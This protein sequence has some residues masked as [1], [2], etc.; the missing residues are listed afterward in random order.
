NDHFV[1]P[2]IY[3]NWP[4]RFDRFSF[5]AVLSRNTPLRESKDAKS[6]VI[7][8]LSFDIVKPLGEIGHVRLADGR[9]GWA[10]PRLLWSPAGYHIE[11]VRKRGTWKIAALISEQ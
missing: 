2:S 1:A 6:K 3:V 4:E 9:T 7:A 11:L 5:I 8:I 10:D